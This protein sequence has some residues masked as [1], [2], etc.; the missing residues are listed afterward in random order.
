MLRQIIMLL[1]TFRRYKAIII[2]FGGYWSLIPPVFGKIFK[3]PVF[4][5]V[6]GTDCASIPSIKYGMLRKKHLRKICKWTY[7]SSDMIF[8]VSESLIY[9]DNHYD[10]SPIKRE[11]KKG[12]KHFFPKLMTTMQGIHNGL[13]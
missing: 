3:I 7:Q 1:F 6:H 2:S 10:T 4:T 9:T 13:N 8:P 11:R 5:I 12:L